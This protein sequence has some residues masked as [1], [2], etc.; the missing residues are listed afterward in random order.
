[1]PFVLRSQ[2]PQY[3]V[4]QQGTSFL[5]FRT[6]IEYLSP[7]FIATRYFPSALGNFSFTFIHFII[8]LL[9]LAAGA[10]S[11]VLPRISQSR[12]SRLCLADNATR[13]KTRSLGS[14]LDLYVSKTPPIPHRS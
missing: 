2:C 1:M 9:L 8:T 14:L 4:Y 11:F 10:I 5:N 3:P 13:E 6:D 7:S 12:N